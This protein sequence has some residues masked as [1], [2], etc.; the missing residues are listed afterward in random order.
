[1]TADSDQK[2]HRAQVDE[3]LQVQSEQ[4]KQLGNSVHTSAER[5]RSLAAMQGV[6]VKCVDEM[7]AA[8][9]GF[10]LTELSPQWLA[11]GMRRDDC[12][13]SDTPTPD[14]QMDDNAI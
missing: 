6:M 3:R 12:E 1:M 13:D 8:L 4:V 2:R 9:A 14:D 5:I 10:M 11:G 7:K